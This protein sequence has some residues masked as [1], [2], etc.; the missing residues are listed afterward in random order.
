MTLSPSA[1]AARLDSL[2]HAHTTWRDSGTINLNAATNSLS[3]RARLALS[4]GFAE[5]GISSGLHSRHHQG[6]RYLDAAEELI[7]EMTTSM[8]K[9]AAADLRAPTGSL[10]N[11]ITIGALVGRDDTI[12]VGSASSL[13]HFSLRAAGWGGHLAGRVIPVPFAADGVTL[14]E[15]ALFASVRLN[16]PAMIVVGSQAM[17][18][19]L[20]L[21]LL[22]R[23]ADEVGALVVYDAAHP[24]G[25]I[26]GG[27]FQSPLTEGADIISS[28]TQKSFPG[29]VGGVIVTRTPELMEP[30][31]TASN[32]FMSNYQNNRVLSFG[33]TVAEMEEFGHEYARETI[34]NART[35]A[36]VFAAE[37]LTPLFA[38]RGAT[39]SNLF[40][41][42]L[43]SH[44]K[45]NAFAALCEEANLI[46]SV[47]R[48]PGDNPPHPFGLRIG[49]HDVTRHGMD[50]EQLQEIGA[51]LGRLARDASAAKSIGVRM[52]ELAAEFS[53]VYYCFENGRPGGSLP[54]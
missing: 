5:K 15:E 11:A 47:S 31:Y 25:L 28:S 35:L 45:A 51:L 18:F 6:G 23:A 12:M 7:M 43:G 22:R 21:G 24:L 38:D 36:D 30:I 41:V 14:D 32:E 1:A 13:G 48:M 4:S 33:Y 46:V 50:S 44:D 16:K 17:L 29:P 26:A 53:T 54:Q 49:A 42:P 39:R 27:Q 10:A 40:L 3:P 2:E 9:G 8:F 19:P 20:D 52:A 37:G 34:R